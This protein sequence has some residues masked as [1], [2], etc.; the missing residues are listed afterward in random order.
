[1]RSRRLP[2]DAVNDGFG[3]AVGGGQILGRAAFADQLHE[4]FPASHLIGRQPGHVLDQRDFQGGGVIARF[5]DADG[6]RID[7]DPLARHGLGGEAPPT[8]GHHL[9]MLGDQDAV[10]EGLAHQEGFQDAVL[11]H[12][13]DDVG[14]IGRGLVEVHVER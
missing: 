8:P 4:G 7:V 10:L 13:S 12:R 11:A 5:E 14:D 1:M 3:L 2:K 9:E 6:D